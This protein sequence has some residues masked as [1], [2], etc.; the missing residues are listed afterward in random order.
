LRPSPRFESDEKRLLRERAVAAR[1]AL[2][3]EA[4]AEA[5]RAIAARLSELPAWRGARTIALYAALGAEVDT[6]EAL[7]L[8]VAAGKRV[9]WPR[10]S[11]EGRTMGFAACAS[12]DLVP[13]P[14]RALEPP[15]SAPV[16]PPSEIDLVA[17]PGVAFDASGGRLGRGRG[18]YDATLPLLP[19]AAWKVGLAFD[20]QVVPAVPREPHDAVL[21]A[22]VTETRTL[23]R[24]DGPGRRSRA[25]RKDTYRER[26]D[27]AGAR[28]GRV[29]A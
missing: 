16:V 9:A 5:S 26:D 6:A 29:P 11:A 21:D 3:A 20:A 28:Y 18:H 2:P 15:P 22:V 7:R 8:A 12:E 24:S 19:L 13:G 14:A 4:R 25:A 1:R 17:V 27:Q 23:T 10:V